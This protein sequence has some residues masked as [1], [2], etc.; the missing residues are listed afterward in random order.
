LV[1]QQSVSVGWQTVF[2]FIS[3]LNIWAFYRIEKLGLGLVII[4]L[5]SVA[6]IAFQ[7][8]LP[9]PWGLLTALGLTIAIPIYFV[10]KWSK[11]WNKKFEDDSTQFW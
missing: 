9:Y 4:I 11:E 10:R 8:V 5:P 6:S 1:K 7:M 2:M 3:I